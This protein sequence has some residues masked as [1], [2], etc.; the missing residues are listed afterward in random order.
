LSPTH[1]QGHADSTQTRPG[2]ARGTSL[3]RV[4]LELDLAA[5]YPRARSPRLGGPSHMACLPACLPGNEVH[6]QGG[7]EAEADEARIWRGRLDARG[8]AWVFQVMHTQAT[9]TGCLFSFPVPFSSSSFFFSLVGDS[10]WLETNVAGHSKAV[11]VLLS[12]T[13]RGGECMMRP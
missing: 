9:K 2:Q 8:L 3:L 13:G 12:A 5:K 6:G 1:H 11:H 10:P 4:R 7:N